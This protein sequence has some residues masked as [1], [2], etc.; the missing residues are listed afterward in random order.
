MPT[1]VPHFLTPAEVRYDADRPVSRRFGDIYHD[2]DGPAEVA[3]V[4]LG[5]VAFEERTRERAGTFTVGE[6][7][8]GTG[9]SFLAA[10][11]AARCRLHFISVERYPLSALDPARSLAPWRNE[12]P[13]ARALIDAYPPLVPGWHR[14]RF[15]GGRVQLSVFFGDV[16]AGLRDLEEQQR[17][18]I[19]AW[20]LDGFAPR[21]NPAMWRR[22]LFEA[23]A[24]LSASRATVT[25]FTAAGEVRRNL[26]MAG[27]GVRR[28]DQRP[29][30]RHSTAGVFAGAGRD[31]APP[32][33]TVVLG[34]GLAGTAAARALAEKGIAVTV[35]DRG[36]RIARG[37]SGIPAAVLHPRLSSENSAL[38]RFRVQAFAF[39]AHRCR[40]LPG[41]T[42]S[43]ALQVPGPS[44]DAGKLRRIASAAPTGIVEFLD[45]DRASEHAGLAIGEPALFFPAALTVDGRSL[46]EA[47]ADH[48]DVEI[49]SVSADS[50]VPLVRATGADIEGLDALEVTGLG[51]QIDRFACERCPRLPIV[52]NST[53][54]PRVPGIPS[55]P[56]SDSVW[57]GAT[58]EY[59]P[60]TIRDA[61]AA[62]AE[63]FRQRFGKAA[64]SSLERFRG[65]RAVTSDRLPVI[66]C[67][68]GVWFNL[69]HGSHGTTTAIL[70]AEIV[71]SAI[72]GEVA[73]VSS[74]IL[75]LLR[76][77]RFRQ[78]QQ[79]RPNPFTR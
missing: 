22:E 43:G 29:H 14:R 54:I 20:F 8:F 16:R 39:A 58:Y 56:A 23:A 76:P 66:G 75:R 26:A 60:W 69:G 33:K 74:D 35:H 1:T 21:R 11:R 46:S 4:F 49:A 38:A 27:F 25:T 5:P 51:G 19:D 79:R 42:P 48:P 36:E 65:I 13:M 41:T 53:F 18:G 31:F 64:G 70:G 62:N 59:R 12:L 3:R 15:D 52:G 61:T 7:G 34:A 57:T 40:G 55:V 71:A 67:D 30:K 45:P 24:R 2:A 78:R 17:R 77:N 32:P 63:R 47:L 72:A 73:P 28:V 10:A 37:A 50:A 9:L 6:L 44:I 68:Q